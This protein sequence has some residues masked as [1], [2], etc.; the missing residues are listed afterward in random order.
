MRDFEDDEEIV[1]PCVVANHVA[2]GQGT[3]CDS[4]GDLTR[5]RLGFLGLLELLV[6]THN[7]QIIPK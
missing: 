2:V 3:A 5:L 4:R 1:Q 6:A 7:Q